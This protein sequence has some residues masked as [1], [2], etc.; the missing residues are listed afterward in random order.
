[1]SIKNEEE[2]RKE[3][4]KEKER[5]KGKSEGGGGYS[6]DQQATHLSVPQGSLHAL[7]FGLVKAHLEII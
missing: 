6:R 3:R 1:M 7:G 5:R 4:K 2:E